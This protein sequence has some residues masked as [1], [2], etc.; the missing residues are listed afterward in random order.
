MLGDHFFL[1]CRILHVVSLLLTLLHLF[2]TNS[3][4]DARQNTRS[5]RVVCLLHTSEFTCFG[6]FSNFSAQIFRPLHSAFAP[7]SEL[8][9]FKLFLRFQ[10]EREQKNLFLDTYQHTRFGASLAVASCA[11]SCTF[12]SKTHTSHFLALRCTF[13]RYSAGL[14]LKNIRPFFVVDQIRVNTN[15][16]NLIYKSNDIRLWAHTRWPASFTDRAHCFDPF[17]VYAGAISVF[18]SS[19]ASPSGGL[20]RTVV[21]R[22][23]LKA[24][25]FLFSTKMI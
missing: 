21:L 14:C 20:M 19:L 11:C 10:R 6:N 12:L 5:C 15:V 9:F 7:F 1:G 8:F 2:F 16:N 3:L 24:K 18:F 22:R 25:M 23:C 17:F 13:W 4:F